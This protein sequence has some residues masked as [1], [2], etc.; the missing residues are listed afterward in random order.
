MPLTNYF[1]DPG[2]GSDVTGD[3]SIGTPW[4]TVQHALDTIT[5]DTANGDQISIKAGTADVLAATLDLT[6]YGTPTATAPLVLRGYTSAANDGGVGVL[7]GGGGGF[8]LTPTA[9]YC[10]YIDLRL[11]NVTVNNGIL[12]LGSYCLAYRCQVDTNAGSPGIGIA[13]RAGC[14]VANCYIYGVT[15]GI[16]TGYGGSQFVCN[17]IVI[18]ASGGV[19]ILNNG[20]SPDAFL[21]NIIVVTQANGYGY[22][23]NNSGAV[24]GLFMHNIVY[25]SAAGTTVGIFLND[26]V[27]GNGD[28]VMNNIIAGW[29]GVGGVGIRNDGATRLTACNAFY[30]NTANE[31]HAVGPLLDLGGDVSLAA[32]PFVDAAN[33]DFR[34]TETAKTALRSLGWPASYLGAD[35][36]TDPHV[37]IGPMQYGPIQAVN[38]LRGRLG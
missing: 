26:N 2:G 29:S 11:T 20:T 1:V 3:G 15:R 36:D 16:Q 37:T 10:G 21:G 34:L 23:A 30:N 17:Y 38:L 13:S 18:S 27:G 8:N 9:N 7:S 24:Q 22:T 31:S 33:G 32:D 14:L 4:A 6:T 25:N 19:G 12:S 5:R 28:A 35:A